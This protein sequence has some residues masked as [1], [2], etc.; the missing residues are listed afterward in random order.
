MAEETLAIAYSESTRQHAVLADNG[1]T[2]WLYL[3]SPSRGRSSTGPVVATA[4]AYNRIAPIELADVKRFRPAPPPIADAYASDVAVC[5]SPSKSDWQIRMSVEAG[6]VVLIRDN[7]PWCLIHPEFAH[8]CSK[9][10]EK[11][12]PWGAPWSA[13][14]FEAVDWLS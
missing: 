10:I 2:A 7:S 14:V 9:A 6:R 4:F 12:G 3:H 11:T 1:V 5:E 13:S 8:G